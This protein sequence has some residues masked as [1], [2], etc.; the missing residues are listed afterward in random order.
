MKPRLTQI[1]L[2]AALVSIGVGGRFLFR[3]IPNFTPTTALALF[4]GFYF[5]GRW[6]ALAVPLCVMLVSNLWLP[7]YLTTG[8]MVVIYAALSWPVLLGRML[9][10]PPGA[11]V[12]LLAGGVPSLLF[13]VASNFA[14][15]AGGH[16][17]PR[18]FDG[19]LECY[20]YAL[21]FYRWMLTADLMFAAL[22]FG[23]YAMTQS[24]VREVMATLVGCHAHVCRRLVNRVSRVQPANVST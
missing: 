11:W 14:V 5:A 8:E 24:E 16:L 9:K 15:W 6:T 1:S 2:F 20:A 7:S 10:K 21:P 18:T 3:D 12:V 22:L 23:G 4:A 17:Y 19:L 13:F